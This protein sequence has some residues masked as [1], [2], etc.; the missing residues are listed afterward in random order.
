MRWRNVQTT[1]LSSCSGARSLVVSV[2]PRC[3]IG[4]REPGREHTKPLTIA[5]GRRRSKAV[6]E[7][8]A[9]SETTGWWDGIHDKQELGES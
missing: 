6:T 3:S 9:V 1:V 5:N 8:A 4:G 2:T 7:P